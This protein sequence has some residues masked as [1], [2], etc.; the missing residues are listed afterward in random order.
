MWAAAS[1]ASCARSSDTFPDQRHSKHAWGPRG[2]V[3]G[4]RGV[5]PLR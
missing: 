1:G 5:L 4:P 2:V 3:G